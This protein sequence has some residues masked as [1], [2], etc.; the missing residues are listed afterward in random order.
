MILV[1]IKYD[2][3]WRIPHNRVGK[4]DDEALV[5]IRQYWTDQYSFFI[6]RAILYWLF[7]SIL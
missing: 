1:A 4:F 6:E 7:L 2:Y 5:E 3:Y